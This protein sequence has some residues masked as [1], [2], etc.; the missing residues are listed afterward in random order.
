[1]KSILL[2]AAAALALAAPALAQPS[3]GPQPAPLPPPIEPPRDVVHPG[4]LKVDVDATDLD[5]RIFRVHETIP[6]TASGP[7]TLL[8]PEWVP[9]GHS[10]RL[11][12]NSSG[13][14]SRRCSR[15]A[16]GPSAAPCGARWEPRTK[17]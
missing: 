2:A 7:M 10:P 14:M 4:V 17:W 13:A 1:V 11:S 9:G 3:P 5:R 6:V 15:G 8:Y 12:F 16:G